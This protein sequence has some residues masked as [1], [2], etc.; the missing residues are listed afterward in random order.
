MA[1]RIDMARTLSDHNVTRRKSSEI[2]VTLGIVSDLS[3][4]F[5]NGALARFLVLSMILAV[6]EIFVNLLP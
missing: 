3:E 4:K 2:L 1:I 5:Y 6:H